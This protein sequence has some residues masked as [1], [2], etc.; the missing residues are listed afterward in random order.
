M[1]FIT[2]ILKGTEC[3]EIIFKCLLVFINI[4]FSS[5]FTILF[6]T[7]IPKPKEEGL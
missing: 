3:K 6:S 4:S 1:C 5:V 7:V 2:D